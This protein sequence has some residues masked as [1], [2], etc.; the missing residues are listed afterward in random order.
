MPVASA[1]PSPSMTSGLQNPAST[2]SRQS[3][4]AVGT[5]TGTFQI[6]VPYNG[7][8]Y[9]TTSLALTAS[10]ADVQ[11]AVNTALSPVSGSV[12]VTKTPSGTGTLR[13]N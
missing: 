11:T 3:T 12:S 9:T 5:A 4:L 2:K 7:R 6:A 10:A 13:T 8:T 1:V